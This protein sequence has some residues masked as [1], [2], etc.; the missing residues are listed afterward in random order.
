MAAVVEAVFGAVYL[1]SGD[2]IEEVRKVMCKLDL[3]YAKYL[4]REGLH[5]RA[6]M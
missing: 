2:D 1:D 4:D 3:T 6:A 5:T